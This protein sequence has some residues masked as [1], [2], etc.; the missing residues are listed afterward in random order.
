MADPNKWLGLMKWSMKYSDGTAPSSFQPM[1]KEDQDFLEKV[2]KE[3]VM[4]ETE[5]IKQVLRILDGENPSIVF[6][7][8][9][10]EIQ[11]EK[12]SEEELAEYKDALLDELLTRIDQI[13]NAMN[14]VKMNGLTILGKLIRDNQRPS[15]R[16]LAAEVCS[17][18]VQ[19]NPFC[20]DAA[21]RINLLELF[22]L[23]LSC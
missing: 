7:K 10:E 4:D 11:E 20:Q 19:N 17:V 1:K 16:A 14:L 12:V 5:R 13:D 3:G 22:C 18:I 8:E 2:L 15:T 23:Q 9:G 6:A 21:L